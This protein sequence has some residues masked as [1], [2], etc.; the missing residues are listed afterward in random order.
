MGTY[1]SLFSVLLPGAPTF[2]F[3]M[4]RYEINPI[5]VHLNTKKA[6]HTSP[7]HKKYPF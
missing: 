6:K 5:S 1:T 7:Y 3:A 4:F 2:Q